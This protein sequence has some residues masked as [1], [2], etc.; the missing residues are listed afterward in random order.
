MLYGLDQQKN[1]V[2]AGHWPLFRYNPALAQEGKNPFQ[3][4]SRAPSIPLSKYTYNEGRYT[5]LVHSDPKAAER[6]L[7]EAEH[8]VAER[9]KT[10]EYLASQ[11]GAAKPEVKS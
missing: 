2:N 10:Y 1:A 7:H 8:D 4:D 3:L 11:P 6:L 9:W 5:M